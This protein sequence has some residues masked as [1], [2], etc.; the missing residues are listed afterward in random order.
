MHWLRF[1]FALGLQ[2][3]HR[4]GRLAVP[5]AVLLHQVHLEALQHGPCFGVRFVARDASA[6]ASLARSQGVLYEVEP[7]DVGAHL[8]QWI[9]VV[10]GKVQRDLCLG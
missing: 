7:V 5:N 4:A 6:R 3:W 10:F 1:L 9:D 2:R 8:S